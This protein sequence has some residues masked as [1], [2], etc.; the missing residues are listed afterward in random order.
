MAKEAELYQRLAEGRVRCTACARYCNI[1]EGKIGFCGIRQN[2]K[3][4]LYLLVYGKITASHV[5]PIEKK[6]LTHYMPGTKIF[7]ISTTGCSWSCA[8]CQNYDMSQRRVVE[9]ADVTPEQIVRLTEQ[10]GCQSIAYTYNEPTIFLEFAHDV[11]VLARKEGLYN[12]F[13][14]NGYATPEA[15]KMMSDFLDAIT[16][17]FKGNGETNFLR[18]NVGIPDAGP[19][20]QTLLD[21]KKNTNVHVEITDLIVPQIGDNLQEARKL[22]RWIYDN[23]GPDTPTHFLRFHPD[24][25]LSHL[26]WTPIE[27]L[28]RHHD[29]AKAEGLKYV[30]IGNAPGH[31]FENTYCAGCGSVVVKRYG[32]DIAGW[33]MDKYNNCLNCGERIPIV[34]TFSQSANDNRFFAVTLNH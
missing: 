26:P 32:F 7:S 23:L 21:L 1:P 6:P 29:V 33:Y 4:R 14:S 3:G 12:A 10:Y 16:V 2:L 24:Y 18:R 22:S 19:I 15:V 27:T 31:P 20:Y 30:Y 9:G 11:G 25:K 8:Y 17:D 28:E 13:V 34:G 5:D